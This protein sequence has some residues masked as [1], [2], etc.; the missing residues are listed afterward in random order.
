MFVPGGQIESQSLHQATSRSIL[1][2]RMRFRNFWPQNGH[3]TRGAVVNQSTSSGA[4]LAA[5]P[6]RP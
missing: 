2:N 6:R 5:L 1:S 3:R 4:S